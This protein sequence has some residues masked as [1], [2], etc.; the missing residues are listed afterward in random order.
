M[1]KYIILA[2]ILLNS[3]SQENYVDKLY[4]IE[5]TYT[6]SDIDTVRGGGSNKAEL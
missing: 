5:I 1:K 2:L 3:C 4:T 6:N